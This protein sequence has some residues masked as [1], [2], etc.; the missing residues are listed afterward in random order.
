MRGRVEIGRAARTHSLAS[1]ANAE[2]LAPANPANAESLVILPSTQAVHKSW[3]RPDE[4]HL[5]IE[6]FVV[7]TCALDLGRVS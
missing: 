1:P 3:S 5:M 2:S 4:F 7:V 6:D